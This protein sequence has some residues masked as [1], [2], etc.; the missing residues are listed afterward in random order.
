MKFSIK[1][2]YMTHLLKLVDFLATSRSILKI[3]IHAF[4]I[5]SVDNIRIFFNNI[6]DF[7]LVSSIFSMALNKS[8]QLEKTGTF[9]YCLFNVFRDDFFS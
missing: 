7:L 4:L 6:P 2:K 1:S 5:S 9:F 8:W 3:V